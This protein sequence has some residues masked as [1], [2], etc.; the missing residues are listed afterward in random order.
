[1]AKD[2]VEVAYVLST[3]DIFIFFLSFSSPSSTRIF[4]VGDGGGAVALD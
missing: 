4:F 2:M 1:M 3:I